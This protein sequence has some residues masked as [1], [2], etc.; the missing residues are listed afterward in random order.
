M[1]LL[2]SIQQRIQQIRQS[3]WFNDAATY[4]LLVIVPCAALLAIGFGSHAL[5][6][7]LPERPAYIKTAQTD[8]K[9]N[10]VPVVPDDALKKYVVHKLHERENLYR[11]QQDELVK[12]EM[13]GEDEHVA[14]KV[15]NT[16]LY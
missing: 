4:P 5:H 10:A 8:Y 15:D 11:K 12:K 16:N 7:Q 13:A 6:R 3:P 9:N 14:C 1:P 2:N